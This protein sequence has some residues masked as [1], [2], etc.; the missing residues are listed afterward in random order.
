MSGTALESGQL[1]LLD[2]INRHYPV[3]AQLLGL[4][5]DLV[6]RVFFVQADS[7]QLVLKVY[8][9]R[10]GQN[11]IRAAAVIT[12]LQQRGYPVPAVIRTHSGSPHVELDLAEGTCIAVLF[13]H[14]RGTE[15]D[16]DSRIQEL[17]HQVGLLHRLMRHYC[18]VLPR[19]GRRHFIDRFISLLADSGYSS[20][21]IERLQQLGWRLWDRMAPLPRGFCH[22]D[23]HA[24]NIITSE[25]GRHVLLDFD[26][27]SLGHPVM[28]VATI[29]D[30]TDFN[31]LEP[32]AYDRTAESLSRFYRSYGKH[33]SLSAAEVRASFCFIAI[34]HF[35]LIPTVASCQAERRLSRAFMD[36][37]YHWLLDWERLCAARS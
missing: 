6:G 25:P 10:H 28:D 35:E 32:A 2:L 12:Y 31:R 17:G 26:A 36:Q 19:Y 9:S 21:R 23:L 4:H 15:P 11:G 24:G 1:D 16:L 34:R 8:R 20:R 7:G 18:G 37:Q 29:C 27:A 33:C 22:G 3:Q 30:R 14:V 13:Q 5:R